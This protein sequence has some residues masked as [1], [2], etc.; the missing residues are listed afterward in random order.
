MIAALTDARLVVVVGAGGVGK[1]T[2]AAALAVGAAAQ[3]DEAMVMTFDPSLRL[4]DALGIGER[5]SDGEI[6]VEL[7]TVGGESSPAGLDGG[8]LFASLLDARSTFDRLIE[9]YAPDSAS[10]ERILGN[11]F[12]HHLSGSLAGILEYMAVERLF[13]VDREGRFDRVILDTP[14]TAQALDFLEAP[15]RILGFLDS[16]ALKVAQY[17][18]FDQQGRLRPVRRFGGLGR[19]VERYL[20]RIVGL[21][22]LRDI[23]EFFRAFGPLYGGFRQRA[24]EVKALLSAPTTA[25]VLVAGPGE[26]RIADCLFFARRLREA[27][28][29]LAAVLVNQMHPRPASHVAEK[30]ESEG[31]RLMRWLGERDL[32][33]LNALR[34]L[35]G[36][37]QPL[38]ALPL[39][40][41]EPTDIGLLRRF[42]VLLERQL[43]LPVDRSSTPTP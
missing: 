5:A 11:R 4:K 2:I 33:G 18:W 17:P 43:A 6:E 16:G 13:E 39:L 9:R 42:A 30:P 12:Y 1:T 15:D 23:A 28:Y 27:G 31:M 38:V 29:R 20:D 7:A 25:F 40:A 10:R 26:E 35:L 8:R 37:E 41:D 36:T 14:P 24:S 21:D 22:L 3:G 32:H 19:G 34:Q